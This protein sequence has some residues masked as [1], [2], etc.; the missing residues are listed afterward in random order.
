MEFHNLFTM[1]GICVVVC[2]TVLLAVLGLP[3]LVGWPLTERSISR[4]T[5]ALV[6]TGLAAAAAILGLMLLSGIRLVPIDIGVWV[7]IP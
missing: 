4:F 1:L 5:Q 2:P 3:A 6:V 7:F